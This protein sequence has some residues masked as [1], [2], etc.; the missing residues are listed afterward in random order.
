MPLAYDP[1]V[2]EVEWAPGND[3]L[4]YKGHCE[5]CGSE[6]NRAFYADGHSFC[7]T[8][9]CGFLPPPS[10]GSLPSSHQRNTKHMPTGLLE[11]SGDVDQKLDKRKLKPETL[12]KFGYFLAGHAGTTVHVAPIYD[13]DGE[14]AAQKLRGPNKDFQ[15]LY[16]QANGHPSV[17]DMRPFGWHVYGDR[18]DRTV[19]V[20]EGELDCM[21]V[22]QEA[23]QNTAVVS[24]NGGAASAVRC[25]KKNY[26]W[27]DRFE[28]I[29]LWFDND[30]AGQAVVD[31]C[32]SLFKVGKVKI[33]KTP[34]GLKDASDL[35]QNGYPGDIQTTLYK[36][37]TWRPRGIINGLD[38]K[39]AIMAPKEKVLAYSYPEAMENLQK[40]TGGLFAGEV[41]YH[42]AGTGVGKSTALREIEYHL[43]EQGAK[44]AIMSFEDTLRDAMFGIMS[45]YASQ[46]LHLMDVPDPE[47]T[48]AVE[49][50]DAFMLD[51]H[52]KVFGGGKIELFDAE[53]AEWGMEAIL[54]YV[55]YCAKALDCQVIFIDPISFVASGIDLKADERRV[56]DMVAGEF[57][58]L[59]KELGIHI[60]IAHHL[61]RTSNGIPHEEGAPTSLNELRSS[62]GLA[63]FANY[64]VG[65]ERNNQAEGEGFRVTQ[66]R[67][68][69]PSRRTGA[70]GLADVLYYTESGRLIK[71]PLP[72]PPLGKA[73]GHGDGG[74][75]N[76]GPADQSTDY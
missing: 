29:I 6:D 54:R 2:D 61:K 23:T 47:D 18:Y 76:F 5:K 52:A 4:L 55:R 33:A 43:V 66:S 69:K 16:A 27:F 24:L 60:V 56:L 70:S 72:F 38:A 30:E 59:A 36:A 57:S 62:G 25:L 26:L 74:Q 37:T 3:V 53:T 65:W 41:T 50:Y 48:K 14:L 32:A 15:V 64:V 8:P 39:L 28:T 73:E 1:S 75:K 19:V 63:N 22:A 42:V 49:K 67:I 13:Q 9:G 44:V 35:L 12:K 46:R 31:E 58:K 34:R 51:I 11:P 40:M 20:T 10:D 17:N 71:S 21:S 68:L 7:Y 45:I